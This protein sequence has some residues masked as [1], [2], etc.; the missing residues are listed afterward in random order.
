MTPDAGANG[1]VA[2]RKVRTIKQ[3]VVEIVSDS[4]EGAQKA[5][6]A[7]GT[8]SA[9]M[10]NGIWTVEIIPAEIQP[11]PRNPAGASGIRVRVG[12][13]PVTNMGD[14]V[15]LTVAFNEQALL[16]RLELARFKPDATILLENKWRNHADPEIA[17]AYGTTYA[18][19]V[20]EGYNVVEVPMEEICFRY[21]NNPQLG[22][23]M[24]VLGMLCSVYNRNVEFARD[25]IR[26][27]FRKKKQKVVDSNI[28]LLNAGYEWARENVDLS[29]EIPPIEATE[30]QIVV[31]GNQAI[32][33]GVVASGM[34]VCAMYPITPATSASHYLSEIFE[35]VGGVVHQAEDEIA[36]AAF[37]V[38]ASYAGKCAVTI[39]SGP[40]MSLKTEVLGLA[41]MAEIPL[42]VVNV[43]RGGP[44]T[45]LPTKTEQGDLL[46]AIFG[47]HGDAPKVVMAPATIEDCFYSV[48]TARRISETFRMPVYVLSDANLA[49]GQAPF[50]RPEFHA[51]WVAPPIDQRPLEPG[52]KPYDWDEK[53]GLSPRIVPGQQNGMFAV[54]GLAHTDAG[55]VAYVPDANQEG[56]RKRS[57]KLAAL[58]RTLKTPTVYGDEEGELLIVGWGSTKGAID[59]AVDRVRE[60]GGSVSALHLTFLQPLAPGIGEILKRYK[61]VVCVEINY[62]DSLDDELINDE[63]RRYSNL[64]WLLRARYLVD[65]KNWTNVHGQPI[66]PGKIEEMIREQLA[67]LQPA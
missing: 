7:F 38:G 49:T 66:G 31:N 60:D 39:T 13:T 16:G 67:E 45:G 35:N 19:L 52:T 44:S 59:E 8:V 6:Q 10:G 34:D 25:T 37:A 47:T 64:S 51:E 9:K 15:D 36:A 30:R 23:N 40:G 32:A 62:S 29:F 61:R 56:S 3:H 28:E 5:G 41:S 4:G 58:Q 48:I 17:S 50:P 57:L 26:Y 24:F 33:L 55:K 54:T 1:T 22:K 53:T 14:E 12:S 20:E 43:Q 11:P 46:Q 2:E 21:V 27:I 18:R 65:V 63:N 42:V